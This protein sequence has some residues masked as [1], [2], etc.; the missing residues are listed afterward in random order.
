MNQFLNDVI[1]LTQGQLLLKYW[2]LWIL[3]IVT[4]GIYLIKFR[5]D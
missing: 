3:I 2:W 4:A 5:K 1:N